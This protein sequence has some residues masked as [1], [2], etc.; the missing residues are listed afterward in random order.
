MTFRPAPKP[1][2]RTK[3]RTWLAKVGKKGMDWEAFKLQVVYPWLWCRPVYWIWEP[4]ALKVHCECDLCLAVSI[5][6]RSFGWLSLRDKPDENG[7][8]WEVDNLH[9]HHDTKRSAE[10]SEV[11][12][13][14]N[15]K[16]YATECHERIHRR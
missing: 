9:I 6:D 7:R 4:N 8:M 14:A 3:R 10:P 16:P 15:C 13:L 11:F 5:E 2:P 1:E 12:V